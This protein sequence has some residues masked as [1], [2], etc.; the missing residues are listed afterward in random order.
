MGTQLYTTMYKAVLSII[1]L[2]LAISSA[3]TAE[4]LK[5]KLFIEALCPDSKAAIKNSFTP[6][7]EKGLLNM[8]DLDYIIAGNASDEGYKRGSGLYNFKCQHGEI[9]CQTNILENCIVRL[10]SNRKRALETVGCM[11]DKIYM[12][13][14]YQD[15]YHTFIQC[16]AQNYK[17]DIPSLTNIEN[18]SGADYK[19]GFDLFDDAIQQTPKDHSF[20][21]WETVDGKTLTQDDRDAIHQDVFTWACNQYEGETIAACKKTKT[22]EGRLLIQYQ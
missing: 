13:S 2:S 11:F 12:H 15:T 7:L 16:M 18:C 21:P 14:T 6:A 3:N 5:M 8:V 20:I 1:L 22:D 10:D 17:D 9:E 19:R 4:K